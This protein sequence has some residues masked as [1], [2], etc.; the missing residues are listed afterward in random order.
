VTR[1]AKENHNGPLPFFSALLRHIGNGQPRRT[2][3]SYRPLNLRKVHKCLLFTRDIWCERNGKAQPCFGLPPDQPELLAVPGFCPTAFR[4]RWAADGPP[5]DG[6]CKQYRCQQNHVN[7][8]TP[9]GGRSVATELTKGAAGE[10][11]PK[12]GSPAPC[13][14]CRGTTT[15]VAN[16][17]RR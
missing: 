8:G 1:S 17:Y 11:S 3:R 7:A 15:R 16:C 12:G 6:R 9:D 4:P 10:L 5:A 2:D 13:G 14:P